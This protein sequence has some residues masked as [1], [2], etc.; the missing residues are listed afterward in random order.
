[1]RGI[2]ADI[3][4]KSVPM[5]ETG[6]M[7]AVVTERRVTRAMRR[8][9]KNGLGYCAS[10][11]LSIGLSSGYE[12]V[13]GLEGV[14]WLCMQ[15]ARAFRAVLETSPLT[16]ARTYV[17]AL[18]KRRDEGRVPSPTLVIHPIQLTKFPWP[19]LEEDGRSMP[20]L[21][22]KVQIRPSGSGPDHGIFQDLTRQQTSGQADLSTLDAPNPYAFLG[23][24]SHRWV[25]PHTEFPINPDDLLTS[26]RLTKPRTVTSTP[27]LALH[28]DI[29]RDP[30]LSIELEHLTKPPTNQ[31]TKMLMK[32]LEDSRTT[33]QP[34]TP[35]TLAAPPSALSLSPSG[36][37][38][39]DGLGKRSPSVRGLHDPMRPHSD[40][41][42]VP[43]I[44]AGFV[45]PTEV[46]APKPTDIP[47]P[48]EEVPPKTDDPE[49]DGTSSTFL[50]FKMPTV[51]DCKC[52]IHPSA[53]G[54]GNA[55]DH[56]ESSR[57]AET[58]KPD[59]GKPLTRKP[60]G[61]DPLADAAGEVKDWAARCVWNAQPSGTFTSRLSTDYTSSCMEE[62]SHV[63][64]LRGIITG[65][66]AAY[67]VLVEETRNSSFTGSFFVFVQL[68]AGLMIAL[69][70]HG[71]L[72]GTSSDWG[73]YTG[74]LLVPP[75]AFIFGSLAGLILQC[76]MLLGL[77]AFWKVTPV[78]GLATGGG[79]ACYACYGMWVFVAKIGETQAHHVLEPAV[80]GV[81]ERM[82]E[83]ASKLLKK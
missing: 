1:M 46:D 67:D 37:R 47:P 39:V 79:V 42:R 13:K 71:A 44:L 65:F 63:V 5:A 35:V 78:G 10:I 41:R 8:L 60:D 4:A 27:T 57:P 12:Q 30:I 2:Q 7:K 6:D 9:G 18:R 75:G 54:A 62:V 36:T 29:V 70:L 48:Q 74:L 25:R 43:L 66:E 32:L 11:V 69:G 80:V 76:I 22:G 3:D 19:V 68:F 20:S 52:A 15:Q 34:V 83:K 58:S 61:S 26:R 14:E 59:H 73:K 31:K 53:A 81:V 82:Q 45:L 33:S 77:Y 21:A 23:R 40:L 17:L 38:S 50:G 51:E 64:G 28:D 55:V 16:L 24:Y 56:C 49:T 72:F